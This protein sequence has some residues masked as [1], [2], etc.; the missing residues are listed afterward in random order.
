MDSE[1][2][3]TAPLH[4]TFGLMI[5]AKGRAPLSALPRDE[6]ATLFRR[7]GALLFRHFDADSRAFVEFTSAYCENFSTYQGGGFRWGSLDRE[8]VDG[9]ETL[10]TVTG[11][12]QSFGIPLHGE[13]YYM[14]RRPSVLWFF[15]ENPP[16][17][18]G[19]T[20]LCSGAELYRRLGEP[21]RE[22]FRRHRLKYIRRLTGDEWR[23]AFQM[24]DPEGLRR[25]C[26]ENESTI[27]EN[28]DG[29]VTIEYVSPA[30]R[31]DPAADAEVFINSLL[32]VHSAEQA[33]RA[34]FAAKLSGLPREDSPLVVRTEEGEELPADLVERVGRVGKDLTAKVAWE[35][36]DVLMV[37]NRRIM[38]GRRSCHDRGRR[39]YVRMG[40]PSFAC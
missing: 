15:C 13:M 33:L 39:I 40:E 36:G 24:E 5:E 38:H 16:S 17:E 28:P 35:K 2:F 21:E 32:I 9:N 26:D 6:V 20:T 31:R 27:A 8:K 3:T 23:L 22:F 10:L 18:A 19:E 4:Q 29:S 12:T 30:V 37:D 1:S 34:G 14:S 7:H 25:W 11:S